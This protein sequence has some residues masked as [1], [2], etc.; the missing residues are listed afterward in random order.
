MRILIIVLATSLALT[1]CGRRGALQPP[2]GAA[3]VDQQPAAAAGADKGTAEEKPD[4]PFV[5]DAL[6]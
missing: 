6:I 4:P 5:L 2:P 3:S 1:A